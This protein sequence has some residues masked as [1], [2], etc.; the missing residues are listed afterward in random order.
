MLGIIV[1]FLY[2]CGQILAH[3]DTKINTTCINKIADLLDPHHS[4]FRTRVPTN[5]IF[6]RNT[7]ICLVK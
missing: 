1:L 4:S 6:H 5:L 2:V 7:I 3:K